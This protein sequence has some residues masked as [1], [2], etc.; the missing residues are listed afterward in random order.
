MQGVAKYYRSFQK[1]APQEQDSLILAP[2]F[3]LYSSSV[4]ISTFERCNLLERETVEAY[5]TRVR[6]VEEVKEQAQEEEGGIQEFKEVLEKE[7]KQLE[8]QVLN[9]KVS[10]YET[11]VKWESDKQDRTAKLNET[12]RSFNSQIR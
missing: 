3:N 2:A 1:L 10:L 7:K 6:K 5:R 11:E 8:I 4:R 9:L 12:V